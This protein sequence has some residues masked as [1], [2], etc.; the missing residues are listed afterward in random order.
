MKREI[1]ALLFATDSP[2]SLGR[3]RKLFPDMEP[4]DIKDAVAELEQEYDAA[5]HAFTIVE[6][7]GGWQVATRPDFAPLVERLVATMLEHRPGCRQMFFAGGDLKLLSQAAPEDAVR[8]TEQLQALR[9]DSNGLE[10]LTGAER[11]ARIGRLAHMIVGR[12]RA[13]D[14][15]RQPGLL[16]SLAECRLCQR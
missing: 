2:L 16:G 12:A 9:A 15:D 11:A 1:E 8:L 6:F 5:G 13:C 14:L 3:L 10:T 4:S 7:G